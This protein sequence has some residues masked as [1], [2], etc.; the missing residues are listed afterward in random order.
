MR[1]VLC[2][3]H[4]HARQRQAGPVPRAQVHDA[5]VS[6][7][8]LRVEVPGRQFRA[9]RGSLVQPVDPCYFEAELKSVCTP[10]GQA[11]ANAENVLE[12]GLGA[13]TP[14]LRPAPWVLT[15]LDGRL[16]APPEPTREHPV[17]D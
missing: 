16:V 1:R 15:I 5:S 6:V 17:R 8:V 10:P 4:F 12:N 11:S 14:V 2:V 9:M 13:R 3:A 7:A